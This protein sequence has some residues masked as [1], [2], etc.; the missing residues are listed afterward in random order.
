MRGVAL[1]F[2]LAALGLGFDFPLAMMFLCA[3]AAAAALP[4]SPAGAATQ[5]GA[6]AALLIVSGIARPEAVGFALAAQTLLI[7]AGAGALFLS[8]MWAT[9]RRIAVVV[10]PRLR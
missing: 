3:A 5:V 7:L 1:T 6:G 10:A 4:I 8:V 9:S 2:L